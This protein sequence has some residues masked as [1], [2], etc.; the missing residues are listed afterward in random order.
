MADYY[1][2]KKD[3]ATALIFYR[4]A[5]SKEIA[6]KKEEDRIREQISKLEAKKK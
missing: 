2:S 1:K 4:H 3:N 6:T 5:L